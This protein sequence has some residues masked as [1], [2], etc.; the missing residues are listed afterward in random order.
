MNTH[1]TD[2]QLAGYVHR[3]LTDADRETMNGH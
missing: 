1:L 2:E 3:T